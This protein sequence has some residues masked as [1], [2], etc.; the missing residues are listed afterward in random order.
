MI[1]PNI[2]LQILILT[3]DIFWK[4]HKNHYYIKKDMEMK[5]S[6]VF[7]FILTSQND[8]CCQKCSPHKTNNY[9][10]CTQYAFW[11]CLI[12]NAS[13]ITFK[14]H[15]EAQSDNT[16]NYPSKTIFQNTESRIFLFNIIRKTNKILLRLKNPRFSKSCK[17]L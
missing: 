5:K 13:K 1:H 10:F 12:F 9:R 6:K 17:Q 11:S 2:Q 3:N 14:I 4:K 15:H 7:N 16:V 8:I